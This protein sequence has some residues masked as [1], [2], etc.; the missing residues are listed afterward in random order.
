MDQRATSGWFQR[1]AV[2]YRA[3]N[4]VYSPDAGDA[5]YGKIA[6]GDGSTGTSKYIKWNTVPDR[7]N[8]KVF[9]TIYDGTTQTAG[10]K[11][12][13]RFFVNAVENTN[14]TDGT[15][16]FYVPAS[17]ENSLG[18]RM[19]NNTQGID[20][21][22]QEVLIYDSDQSSNLSGI[23]DNMENYFNIT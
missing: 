23:S 20:G 10:G 6:C 7:L 16:G 11:G 5:N 18:Y 1:I 19:E 12:D 22:M 13:V 2:L 15:A 9:A 21:T 14:H 4:P 17:G 3:Q 8:Q